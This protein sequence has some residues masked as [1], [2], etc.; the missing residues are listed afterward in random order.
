[1]LNKKSA[2]LTASLMAGLGAAFFRIIIFNRFFITGE[3]RFSAEARG[4]NNAVFIGLLLLTLVFLAVSLRIKENGPAEFPVTGGTKI[5]LIVMTCFAALSYPLALVIFGKAAFEPSNNTMLAIP[6][7]GEI[8]AYLPIIALLPSIIFFAANFAGS[9]K[10]S[11]SFKALSVFP[12]VW[13]AFYVFHSYFDLS[14]SFSDANRL[15]CDIAYL[16]VALR[17]L[18]EARYYVKYPAPRA[19]LAISC[20]AVMIGTAYAVPAV[21]MTIAGVIPFTLNCCF[22]IALPAILVYFFIGTA[23]WSREEN[24]DELPRGEK[25]EEDDEEESTDE[26]PEPQSEEKAENSSVEDTASEKQE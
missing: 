5:S 7:L 3:N 10:S 2:L 25:K 21:V 11:S 22:E 12:A 8:A 23:R 24:A 18:M 13:A 9:D 15:L 6:V 26:S 19:F 14:Y 1:M 17:F 16:A 20:A 4:W